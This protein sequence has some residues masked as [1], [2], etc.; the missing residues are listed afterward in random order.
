[1][2]GWEKVRSAK[3]HLPDMEGAFGDWGG[4]V[5]GFFLS[6]LSEYSRMP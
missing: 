4:L 1:M 3:D 2:N 5:L 6:F